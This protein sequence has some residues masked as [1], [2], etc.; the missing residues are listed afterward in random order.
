MNRRI[1]T[2][3]V[4][5]LGLIGGSLAAALRDKGFARRITAFNRNRA[6]LDYA[7]AAGLIDAA[8]QSLEAAVAEADLI[9]V[10]VPTLTVGRIFEAIRDHGRPDVLITDVASVK[11]SVVA[12][13]AAVFGS[14]PPRLV[15]GHPI[16]GAER[17]GVEA[18]HAGLFER[19]RVILTPLPD[20]DD[21]ALAIVDAMWR[22]T[23][24]EVVRMDVAAHDRILA[25]TSHLPHMLAFALVDS[26]ARQ[27]ASEDIFRFAAGGFRDF[28]RI[29]SSDAV[30]WRDIAIT[31]RSALLDAIDG[32]TVTLDAL[33]SAVAAGDAAA[34]EQVFVRARTARER[35][36]RWLEQGIQQ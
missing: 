15:P 31:N 7:L 13:A 36:L 12:A 30:M 25:L 8:P 26:L 20:T 23:G 19:H 10:G 16:A 27:S 35:Y 33:R 5:G 17:S 3:L 34:L 18:A 2:L 9:V 29:A 1:D 21:A 28:T 32:F 4:V 14:V 24:A 22:L 11:G 6:S